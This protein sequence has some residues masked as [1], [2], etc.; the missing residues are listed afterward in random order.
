MVRLV[1][2]RQVQLGEVRDVD[3]EAAVRAGAVGEPL[4]DGTR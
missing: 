3:V 2:Q 1:E 4:C